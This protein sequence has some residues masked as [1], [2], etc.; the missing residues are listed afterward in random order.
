MLLAVERWMVVGGLRGR[1][2][3]VGECQSGRVPTLED[4]GSFQ[5]ALLSAKRSEWSCSTNHTLP[6]PSLS[7][8]LR[9]TFHLLHHPSPFINI[10]ININSFKSSFSSL[11]CLGISST[12]H[13][14]C[15]HHTSSCPYHT[16]TSRYLAEH[17][18]ASTSDYTSSRRNCHAL[19]IDE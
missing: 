13:P 4:V 6:D 3:R 8:S 1:E 15:A 14:S 16:S 10:I 2:G 11:I 19:C 17:S 7:P 9:L 5:V 12:V 18:L